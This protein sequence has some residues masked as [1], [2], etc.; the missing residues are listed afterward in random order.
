MVS[1]I[2]NDII[3]I[4]YDLIKIDFKCI[5]MYKFKEDVIKLNFFV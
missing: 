1:W 3:V 5:Y 2:I 4:D